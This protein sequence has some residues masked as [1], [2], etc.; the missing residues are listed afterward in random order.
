MNRLINA[1]NQDTNQDA[2]TEKG[3]VTNRSSLSSLVDLFFLAG[4]SR[5]KDLTAL[6]AKAHKEDRELALR[7][8]Q[9]MRD[10]REGA[11]ERQ[12]FRNL[13]RWIIANDLE[14]AKL[15]LGRVPE[16]GR[17]DDVLIAL[18][19]PLENDMVGMVKNA[20]LS[21]RNGLCAKWLPRKGEVAAKLRNLLGWT[22]K[23]YRKT[24]VE[25]TNVVETKMC[26]K[27]WDQ[28][29]LQQVPSVAFARYK[30][31][32]SKN[33]PQMF[34]SFVKAV[35]KGEAKIHAS[36]V[37]P[38][39]IVRSLRNSDSQT[40]CD[41]ANEQW[42]ALPNYLKDA[43]EERLLV[44]A[45]VSGSMDQNVSGSVTAMDVCISIALYMSER[46]NGPFKDTFLTFSQRP[47]LQQLSGTLQDR[48]NQLENA[49][50]NMTTNLQAAFDLVLNTAVK[51][52]VPQEEMPTKIVI[53]SDMEFDSAGARSTN[54][55]A[56]QKKYKAA[57]YTM[58]Q[59]VFW[60]VAGRQGNSPVTIS[61]AGTALVS[62]FS[63]A[64]VR[65]VLGC[66]Q[67]TPRD[68]MLE[69]LLKARYDLWA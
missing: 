52:N 25:L 54:F 53:V 40:E 35:Q 6:F 48:A 31:S 8:A 4:A 57:G 5:G 56:I 2:R 32:F 65:S 33:A 38:Y 12:Q 64:I 43:P 15:L 55:A 21:E 9:W 69:T 26:A 61:D 47:E 23:F 24:L 3:A 46:L 66:K 50:W 17:W 34:T 58:P 22:P 60:N 59:V 67:L 63:P 68:V 13:F 14:A 20:L 19:T 36:A 39:D 1:I 10:A 7:M 29:K 41:A 18:D 27:Q 30:R 44:M 49:H 16:L 51:H 45:D 62:G 42:K 28:I 11:G 37:F